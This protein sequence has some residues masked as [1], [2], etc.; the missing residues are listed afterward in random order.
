MMLKHFGV[1]LKDEVDADL[2]KYLAAAAKA[3]RVGETIRA[4]LRAYMGGQRAAVISPTV[5]AATPAPAMI[6]PPL[7]ASG[8]DVVSKAKRAF[9]K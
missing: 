2:I 4:A 3:N 8:E 1:Y 5:N 6:A 9:F 7:P